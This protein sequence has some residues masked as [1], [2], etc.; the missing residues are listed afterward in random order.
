MKSAVRM[1]LSTLF[2]GAVLAGAATGTVA[3]GGGVVAQGATASG[4]SPFI[5]VSPA[6]QGKTDLKDGGGDF[7]AQSVYLRAGASRAMGDGGNRVGITLNYDYT[8]FDFSDKTVFGKAPWG[9]VQRVGVSVP[10]TFRG[11]DG[12]SYGVA[13]SIDYFKENG[14]DWGESMSYGA[15]FTASKAFA[16]DRRIGFG[17]GAFER[18]EKTS[19]FPL[20]LVDW[21]FNERWRLIN[22]LPSGPTGPAGLEL[23]YRLSSDWSVG[24]G[25][26]YRTQRFRL[27]KDGAVAN[28]IGAERGAPVFLRLTHRVGQQSTVFLYAGAIFGGKLRLEDSNGNEL[29]EVKFD[30]QPIIG[31]TILLRL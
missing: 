19:F 14:A 1:T 20:L 30:P 22:P 4:W 25:A 6:I 7:S 23:D 13:P 28:G 8:N 27:S 12:W 17:L 3:Q 5:S 15:L 31:A 26:S 2:A 24:L 21:R 16:A 9:I 10:M 29:R 18:L 11:S